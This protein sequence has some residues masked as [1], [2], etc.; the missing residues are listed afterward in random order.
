MEEMTADTESHLSAA[1][2]LLN[3]QSHLAA[4]K[5]LIQ[6]SQQAITQSHL[7]AECQLIQLCQQ[8]VT[9]SH[10]EAENQL[11]QTYL[12][13]V[14]QPVHLN[15][16]AT[17]TAMTLTKLANVSQKYYCEFEKKNLAKYLKG[18]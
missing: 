2:P 5:Q 7:M 18:V 6:S 13:A 16:S 12:Q 8:A 10:I 17:Q 11:T 15:N 3:T 9:E 4:D 14:C 1:G